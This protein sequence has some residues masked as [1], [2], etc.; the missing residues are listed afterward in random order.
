MLSLITVFDLRYPV[1]FC[2]PI[3][4][5]DLKLNMIGFQVVLI[6]FTLLKMNFPLFL[7]LLLDSNQKALYD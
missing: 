4:L 3:F 5:G 6:I 7:H 2:H 1:L